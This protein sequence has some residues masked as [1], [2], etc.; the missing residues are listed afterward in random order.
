MKMGGAAEDVRD[1]KEDRRREENLTL[2]SILRPWDD[3]FYRT[4]SGYI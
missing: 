2:P 3:D 1:F 4:L